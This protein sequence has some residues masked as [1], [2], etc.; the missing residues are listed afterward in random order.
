MLSP[1]LV[2]PA[3]F[4]E[5]FKK[6]AFHFSSELDRLWFRYAEYTRFMRDEILPQVANELGLQCFPRDYY[7][8]DAIFYD[9]ADRENFGERTTYAKYIAVAIEH[10]N[11]VNGCAI[12]MNKLQLFNAPLKVLITYPG[13]D[14]KTHFQLQKF[15]KIIRDAD[16][17]ADTAT[18]RKQLVILGFK[19]DQPA[20]SWKGFEYFHGFRS[21]D[22]EATMPAFHEVP[23]K[24]QEAST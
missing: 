23:N 9:E 3:A 13:D 1:V 5:A 19:K 4:Y 7:T 2:Q 15:E 18:H 24:D 20:P 12:E 8:L 10:E 16:V 21:L 22:T 14:R 11:Q 6:V 17:F